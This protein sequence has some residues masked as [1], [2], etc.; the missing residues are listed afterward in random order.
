[1]ENFNADSARKI[2][3]SI[4][5]DELHGILVDIKS[6]AEAG[7]TDLHVYKSL[8]VATKNELVVRGF[9]VHNQPSIAIQKENLYYTISWK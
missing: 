1:M 5:N 8:R 4:Q 2:V 3:S 7:E 6:R 9:D